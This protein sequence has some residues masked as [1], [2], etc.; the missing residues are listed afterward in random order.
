MHD[1]LTTATDFGFWKTAD[2]LRSSFGHFVTAVAGWRQRRRLR[3]ELY[4][5]NDRMLKDIGI[6][7]WEIEW[8]VN[9]PNGDHSDR[10]V[11]CCR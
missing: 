10:V 6:S 11:K 2:G 5:L 8:I 3:A 4:A 7:R 9:S 1:Y